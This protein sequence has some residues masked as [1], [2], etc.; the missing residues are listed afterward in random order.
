MVGRKDPFGV[1]KE[2]LYLFAEPVVGSHLMDKLR[3]VHPLPPVRVNV[4]GVRP[5][6][7]RFDS[8]LVSA[9]SLRAWTFQEPEPTVGFNHKAFD[10]EIIVF[11][12][13]ACLCV[14]QVLERQIALLRLLNVAVRNRL[15][16]LLPIPSP[17]RPEKG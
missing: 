3:I 8:D 12:S 16:V 2:Q 1:G 13:F 7:H 11:G 4:F 9:R 5:D 14:E 17:S 6:T 10:G 15:P